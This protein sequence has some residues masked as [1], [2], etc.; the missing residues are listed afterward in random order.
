M[1]EIAKNLCKNKLIFFHGG[2]LVQLAVLSAVIVLQTHIFYFL[3]SS[4][5]KLLLT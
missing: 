4:E 3:V 1:P 2:L 5:T